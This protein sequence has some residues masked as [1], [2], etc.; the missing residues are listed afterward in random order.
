MYS[1][2]S[3]SDRLQLAEAAS[4]DA[5]LPKVQDIQVPGSVQSEIKSNKEQAA[6]DEMSESVLSEGSGVDLD[7]DFSQSVIT[8]GVLNSL[9]GSPSN[10]ISAHSKPSTGGDN[11][12]F[13]DSI[14]AVDTSIRSARNQKGADVDNSSARNLSGE[15]TLLGV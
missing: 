3:A 6:S 7:K 13:N 4:A 2:V 14:S 11:I 1:S 10:Q 12:S 5:F 15:I 9:S 8:G